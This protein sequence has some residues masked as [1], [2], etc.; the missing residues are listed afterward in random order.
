MNK[1]I[2]TSIVALGLLAQTQVSAQDASTT[3]KKAPQRAGIAETLK[4]RQADIEAR[5]QA[6]QTQKKAVTEEIKDLREGLRE[7][8]KEIK[9]MATST[10]KEAR[11]EFRANAS[12]TR[13][14]IKDLRE[15]RKEMA[16]TT[17]NEIKKYKAETKEEIKNQLKL[18]TTKAIEKLTTELKKL[19]DKKN[20]FVTKINTLKTSGV[21]VSGAEQAIT[22]IES[23]IT[24]A[25]TAINAIA[26]F[27]PEITKT[28]DEK[29][30]VLKG[31]A[32]AKVEEL[33][34]LV[35]TAQNSIKAVHKA[36]SDLVPNLRKS[37]ATSTAPT[38]N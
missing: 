38:A 8:H 31:E 5:K 22:D 21:D 20:L 34:K 33:K 27:N 30:E 28:T 11:E 18:N 35:T 32:K 12:S 16:S 4:A 6:G 10:R 24:S 14:E 1:V 36:L 15:E 23:K 7:E 2:I 29:G 13:K 3:P 19:S 26:T 17:R 37:M 9:N 25:E